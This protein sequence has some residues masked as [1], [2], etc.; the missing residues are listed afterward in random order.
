MTN[1]KYVF[2]RKLSHSR[3]FR[4][5]KL[6]TF[7]LAETSTIIDS[8]DKNYNRSVWLSATRYRNQDNAIFFACFFLQDRL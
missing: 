7:K 6:S 3:T 8:I 2:S 5:L 4:C 1:V